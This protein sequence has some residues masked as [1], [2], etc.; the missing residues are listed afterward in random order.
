MLSEAVRDAQRNPFVARGPV[1]RLHTCV[2]HYLSRGQTLFPVYLGVMGLGLRV[3]V[4]VEGGGGG[5]GGAATGKRKWTQTDIHGQ[6]LEG[7]IVCGDSPPSQDLSSNLAV[8][9]RAL[10]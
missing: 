2:S 7:E 5:V 1:F 8:Q 4:G 6:G 3:G 10:L 9:L